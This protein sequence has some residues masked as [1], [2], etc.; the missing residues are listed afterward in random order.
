MKIST[1]FETDYVDHSS[2][3]NI[4]KIASYTDG[5][6]NSGRKVIYT[7]LKKNIKNDVKVS[8]L[9]ST[10][11]ELTEYLHGEDNLAGVIVGMAKRYVGTNNIPLLTAEGNFGKRLINEASADRYIFT[12]GETYLEKL[13]LK[14]DL[15][16]LTK[17][18]FE[19]EEI[20][21]RFFTPI[22]PIILING[23]TDG[24]STGFAQKIY[25]RPLNE[26][27]KSTL[28]YIETGV[29]KA[30]KPNWRGFK[31]RV[32]KGESHNKWKVYGVFERINSTQ[33]KITELPISY[34]LKKYK[35]VLNK[36]EEDGIIQDYKDRS[37]GENF[38]FTIKVTRKFSSLT[39]DEIYSKLKLIDSIY[40]NYTC[41][42]EHNKISVFEKIEDVFY[43]YAK[44][45]EKAYEL[46]KQS[47]IDIKKETL[48]ILASKFIFVKSIIEEKIIVNDKNKQNIIDQIK[49]TKGITEKDGSYD[50]LLNMPIFSLTKEK[51]DSLY[52]EIIRTKEELEII[53]NTSEKQM[54]KNDISLLTNKN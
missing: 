15:P 53:E 28:E 22:L 32:L 4:R 33:L 54:W 41:V 34:D 31:G 43:A 17:Q 44:V 50:F 48:K 2:Y 52:E 21:P 51:K 38:N 37:S 7:I 24:I 35:K 19:G 14:D 27:L 42:N 29:F 26:I 3:D 23:S 39:D 13:F 46:R 5:L 11:S 30:P 47:L 20:E 12:S 10:V 18:I 45:R 6:K 8:R 25:A 36:L 16:I 40:E 1:F 9:K 49:N